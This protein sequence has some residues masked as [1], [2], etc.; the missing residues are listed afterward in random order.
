MVFAAFTFK[1]RSN[2]PLYH[3]KKITIDTPNTLQSQVPKND[4]FPSGMFINV[5][6][7]DS[8]YLKSNE[9]KTKAFVIVDSKE[10]GNVGNDYV[11]KSGKNY[12]TVVIYNPKEAQIQFGVKGKYGVIKL[13]QKDAT[14]ITAD[15]VAYDEKNKSIKLSGNNTS[16]NG[17]FSNS[18]IYLEDKI[19]SPDVLN[20]IAPDKISSIRILKGDKI[21][22][23]VDAKG[24]TSVIYI[25]LKPDDLPGIVVKSKLMQNGKAD[26]HL[27]EEFTISTTY[28]DKNN[29]S[30][31]YIGLDNQLK[32]YSSKIK[33]DDLTLLISG[34]VSFSGNNGSYNVRVVTPGQRILRFL[35]KDGRSIPVSFTINAQRVPDPTDPDFPEQ[36]RD[37]L[38]I[39][40]NEISV[41][42][43][44]F[45]YIGPSAGGTIRTDYLKTQKIRI[46]EG[47]RFRSGTAWFVGPGFGDN[48]VKLSLTENNLSDVEQYFKQCEDGSKIV[49]DNISVFDKNG[50]VQVV[51]PNPVFIA[52]L[53]NT[54]ASLKENDLKINNANI[55]FTKVEQNPQFTG[56]QEA[57]KNFLR[58]NLKPNTPV[59]EGWSAGKFTIIV[60]FIVHTDGTVSDVT[61]ENYK[62]TKTALHCIEVIKNA[63]KWQPA[64]QNGRKVNAYKKQPITFLIEE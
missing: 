24:K 5:K 56:G 10:I 55:T 20:Q 28:T 32:V 16:I 43:L 25:S 40:K 15:A 23:V 33:P 14:F 3:G 12:S 4:T 11:E 46:L 42:K 64:V 52:G 39:I 49:F 22:D 7:A 57:W 8:N 50:V 51:S 45:I 19:I 6:H 17:D 27:Q 38:K 41:D 35:H 54:K 58:A 31:F 34:D 47:C 26:S 36:L 1:A 62:G 53:N 60:K 30:I 29:V 63:P 18:L 48:I 13:T 37:R 44:P 61:T 9:F 59:D 2:S 21:K